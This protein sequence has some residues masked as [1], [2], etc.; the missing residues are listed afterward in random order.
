MK[1]KRKRRRRKRWLAYL[2]LVMLS[3]MLGGM[4]FVGVLYY[5][6]AQ[7]MP[8][9]D[10]LEGYKPREASYIYSADGVLLAQI[11]E[12]YR[13]PAALSEIPKH[14]INATIAKE[15]RRFW[16][17]HGIDWRGVLRAAW[18]NLTEGEIQQGGSTLTQQLARNAFLTQ[19]RTVSRKIQEIILAQELERRL[20]KER[21][22]ELYLNQVYYGNG[23]YGVKAAARVYFNKSLD[24]LTLA[25]CALLAALPQRPSSYEPFGNPDEALRQR[26]LVLDLMAREGYITPAQREA[27]KREPLRLTK[28]RP[29]M[30]FVAPYA[31]MDA[32]RQLEELYGREL[33]LQG[34]LRVYTTLH[35]GMQRAAERALERGIR[36]FEDRG[37][38]QGAIVLIDL[39]TGG[40]R[41]LVG[42]RN[43]YQSQYNAITQGRRQPGSA[44]KP[45]VYAAAFE[46]GKLKPTSTL[47]DAPLSLPSGVPGK[48]WRPQNADGRFRGRVSVTRAL[49][50]SIN[51]PAVRAAMLV[52]ADTIA[53]FARER[54]GFESPMDPVLPIALGASAVKPI[55]MAEAF[56]VFATH[57]N[58]IKPIL[59]RRVVDRDGVV[60][61]DQKAEVFE[62]VLSEQ[63]AR[64][65]DEI[66]RVA[67][68]NG[69]GR[70]ARHIPNARG[71]TGTTSDHR[72]AWFIGY[73]DRY[74]A[75]V[76]VASAHYDE[77]A[78]RW[79][80]RPM[81]RV[82]GGTV[83]TRI[84]ADM[85]EE[86]L[87]IDAQLEQAQ[88]A[89]SAPEV[90]VP[91][92]SPS[93]VPAVPSMPSG[94]PT[95]EGLTPP[96]P[97]SSAPPPAVSGDT[98][99]TAPP[100]DSGV[101]LASPNAPLPVAQPTPSGSSTSAAPTPVGAPR[102]STPPPPPP[103]LLPPKPL[104]PPPP[105]PKPPETVTVAICVDTGLRA[106][107]YCPE[108]VR[109]TFTKGSEPKSTC[110]KH[111]I[112]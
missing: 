80:Y 74:L 26:N 13:E 7:M 105:P 101:Q 85:M 3:L 106:T 48:P 72:D 17:H 89:K 52:G 58:R 107:D 73:T 110:K 96:L 46:L 76:W 59:I 71:K 92:P 20:S 68:T 11:A 95:G 45:I 18:V 14:L 60:L 63:S 65:I 40:I 49:A 28:R 51:L 67:V 1:P 84:W 97:E 91:S 38:N 25:E 94:E 99:A 104:P 39:R 41:A 5:Q 102:P 87:K 83:C 33:L 8:S 37:V 31:V 53:Q 75:V 42:G 100:A 27:A 103:P 19:R 35:S 79:E 43:F 54:F 6:V 34:N 57:G 44:F 82:F 111:R 10:V 61:L 4:T 12:E 108:V 56:S 24:Q 55:E 2:A 93:V 32:L 15:D 77:R 78:H 88:A 21:I 16:S 62:G 23:A 50:S 112:R 29:R 66:L 69:T 109:R 36:A 86:V 90:G 47:L 64:W 9:V 98:N 81:Q 30:R 70:A 22:L